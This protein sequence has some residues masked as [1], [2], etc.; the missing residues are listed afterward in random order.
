MYYNSGVGYSSISIF[1]FMASQQY[2]LCTLGQLPGCSTGQALAIHNNIIVG[3]GRPLPGYVTVPG[4]QCAKGWAT[5][6]RPSCIK[7]VWLHY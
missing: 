3:I 2:K 1:P 5:A 4:S 6:W 7:G